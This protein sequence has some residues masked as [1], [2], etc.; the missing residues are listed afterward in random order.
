ME[1]GVDGD[2]FTHGWRVRNME[3]TP[4]KSLEG[5]RNADREWP[6][7]PAVPKKDLGSSSMKATAAV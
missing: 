3:H 2:G 7:D 6:E 5:S 1:G 4:W